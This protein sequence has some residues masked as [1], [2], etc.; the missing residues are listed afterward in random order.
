ME[1]RRNKNGIVKLTPFIYWE[2]QTEFREGRRRERGELFWSCRVKQE[3]SGPTWKLIIR[4]L[5]CLLRHSPEQTCSPSWG[6][7]RGSWASLTLNL[8]PKKF[9]RVASGPPKFN[10]LFLVSL[11]IFCKIMILSSFP[12]LLWPMCDALN[13]QNVINRNETICL[14]ER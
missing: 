1:E 4:K 7:W 14:S 2:T 5:D 12:F 13:I 10:F 9:E 8:L 11:S 3:K 6:R